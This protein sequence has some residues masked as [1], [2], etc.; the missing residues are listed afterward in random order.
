MAAACVA[1]MSEEDSCT[2]SSDSAMENKA[3]NLL[4]AV[5]EYSHRFRLK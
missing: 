5:D 4:A 3:I 2:E 1:G